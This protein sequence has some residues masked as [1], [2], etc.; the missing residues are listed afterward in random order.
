MRTLFARGRL[1]GETQGPPSVNIFLISFQSISTLPR[2]SPRPIPT[3]CPAILDFMG[4]YDATI[5]S[6]SVVSN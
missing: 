1:T 2:P 5:G 6:C 4:L 3:G